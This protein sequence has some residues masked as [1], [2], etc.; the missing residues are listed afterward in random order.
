M[1][2]V[3]Q[4]R[5]S[6]RVGDDLATK[7]QQ[8]ENKHNNKNMKCISRV[9]KISLYIEELPFFL[10][11]LEILF[12][13][14]SCIFFSFEIRK[15]VFELLKR[16]LESDSPPSKTEQNRILFSNLHFTI[17]ERCVVGDSTVDYK[18]WEEHVPWWLR[19]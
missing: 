6:Q 17:L 11:K 18:N 5:E 2:G 12:E 16:D 3:L 13:L 7:Q 1:S 14:L 19:Q 10:L 9:L 8:H 4:F 15:L